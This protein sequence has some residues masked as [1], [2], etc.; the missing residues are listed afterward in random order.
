MSIYTVI[1]WN[2]FDYFWLAAISIHKTW[3]KELRK[4]WA[5]FLGYFASA[6]MKH[7]KCCLFYQLKPP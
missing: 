5:Y 7:V 4:M 2:F 3:K 6:F 1:E